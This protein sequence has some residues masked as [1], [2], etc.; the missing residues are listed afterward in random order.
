M[1]SSITSRKS[2]VKKDVKFTQCHYSK[3][4]LPNQQFLQ[5]LR[6]EIITAL[7]DVV[8]L[9]LLFLKKCIDLLR[10]AKGITSNEGREG[11]GVLWV[12]CFY[13]LICFILLS[14]FPLPSRPLFLHHHPHPICVKDNIIHWIEGF[15]SLFLFSLT[16]YCLRYILMDYPV[17]CSIVSIFLKKFW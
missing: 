4:A 17:Q 16:D 1:W 5:W 10:Y 12:F 15:I 7:L 9:R 8:S 2:L 13:P 14:F 3:I 6:W 11:R